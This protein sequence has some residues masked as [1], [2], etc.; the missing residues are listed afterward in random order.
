MAEIA[1]FYSGNLALEV[2]K[3][4]VRK[5][6]EDGTPFR[7]STG[8]TNVCQ[9]INSVLAATVVLDPERAD[10]VRW[11]LEQYGTGE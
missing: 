7:A 9:P 8:Y 2:M 4:L 6:E 11:R 10:L 1:Q 3:G 5:A